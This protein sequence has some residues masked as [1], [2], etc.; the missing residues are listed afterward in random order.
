MWLRSPNRAKERRRVP[1]QSNAF[2][3]INIQ[4]SGGHVSGASVIAPMPALRAP[5]LRV[6]AND[7]SIV[8]HHSIGGIF[9]ALSGFYGQVQ[10]QFIF[11]I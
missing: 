3:N 2:S 9:S 6:Q 5:R 7:N 4:S 1:L 11:W 8:F 10:R